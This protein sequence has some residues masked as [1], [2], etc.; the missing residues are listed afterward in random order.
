MMIYQFH[1]GFGEINVYLY[2]IKSPGKLNVARYF[3][4]RLLV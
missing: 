2:S 4:F 3:I 1:G